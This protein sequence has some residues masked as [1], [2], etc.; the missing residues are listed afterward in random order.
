MSKTS[1]KQD[2]EGKW[3]DLFNVFIFI[4]KRDTELILGHGAS[5]QITIGKSSF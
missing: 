2:I 1:S 3:G 4:E 5:G